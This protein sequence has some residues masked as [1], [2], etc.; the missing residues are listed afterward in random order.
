M[1]DRANSALNTRIDCRMNT[2]GCA[3]ADCGGP[4]R[5]SRQRRTL[6]EAERAR[7]AVDDDDDTKRYG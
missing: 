1:R 7:S 4:R 2:A 5:R 3:D 6:G